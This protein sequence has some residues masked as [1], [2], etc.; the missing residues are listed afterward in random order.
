[1]PVVRTFR[2]GDP[3]RPSDGL[4]IGAVRRPPRG[5]PKEDWTPEGYF[6][7]WLPT[8]APS[9]SLLARLKAWDPARPAT[10]PRFVAAYEL[11]LRKPDARHQIDLLAVVAGRTR[12]SLG[13]YCQDQSRCHRSVLARIVNERIVERTS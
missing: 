2:I 6:D 12:L 9:Q 1:M 10:W 5:I 13:C 4:R 11:E 3:P 8:L 7:V